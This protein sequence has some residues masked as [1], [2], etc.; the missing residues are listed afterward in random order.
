MAASG[1]IAV[2]STLCISCHDATNGHTKLYR[3]I[4]FNHKRN[5]VWEVDWY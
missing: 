5:E 2:H 3:D 1:A 4:L